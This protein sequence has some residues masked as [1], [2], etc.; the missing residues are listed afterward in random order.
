MAVGIGDT[1]SI[2]ASG[3]RDAAAAFARAAA[4]DGRARHD[5]GRRAGVDA[6]AAGQAVVEGVLLARYRYRAFVDRPPRRR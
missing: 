2:D 1:G 5:P 4:R 6:A 3:L